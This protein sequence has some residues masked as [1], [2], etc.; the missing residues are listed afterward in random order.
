MAGVAPLSEILRTSLDA[1]MRTAGPVINFHPATEIP[2][3]FAYTVGN[4]I[5]LE[6]DILLEMNGT[7][8]RLNRGAPNDG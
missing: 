3:T 6:D 8:E 4:S 7:H 5:R 2:V 1:L